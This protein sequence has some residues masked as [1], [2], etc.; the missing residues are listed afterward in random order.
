M[1]VSQTA[2][3]P[4]TF[5]TEGWNQLCAVICRETSVGATEWIE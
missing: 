5:V 2:D 1:S 4:K 3:V